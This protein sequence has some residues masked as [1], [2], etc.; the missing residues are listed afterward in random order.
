MDIREAL[1][2][3]SHRLTT[4]PSGDGATVEFFSETSN[5]PVWGETAALTARDSAFS[6]T[7]AVKVVAEIE[8]R[9]PSALLRDGFS[10]IEGD[11]PAIFLDYADRNGRRFSTPSKVVIVSHDAWTLGGNCLSN[12][13]WVKR[14]CFEFDLTPQSVDG[15]VTDRDG[16]DALTPTTLDDVARD[17][18]IVFRAIE[19]K[20]ADRYLE[21]LRAST[22]KFAR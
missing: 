6:L 17:Y 8:K 20:L 18:P 1:K 3:L 21:S 5:R 19:D 16:T 9:L 15:V 7:Y 14:Q 10:E 12:G 2:N 22:R 4:F 11:E 13:C